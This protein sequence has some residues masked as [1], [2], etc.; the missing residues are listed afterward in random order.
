MKHYNSYD[1]VQ[2]SEPIVF[3]AL[4]QHLTPPA[5]ILALANELERLRNEVMELQAIAPKKISHGGKT[6][7]WHCPDDMIPETKA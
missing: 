2:Y 3:M 4:R 5:I 7:V 1:E 6:Y